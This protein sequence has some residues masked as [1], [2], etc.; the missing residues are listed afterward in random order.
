MK[1]ELKSLFTSYWK[2][3]SIYNACKIKLFDA[4]DVHRGN[5]N[6]LAALH[7]WNLIALEAL[8]EVCSEEGLV[9]AEKDS[10]S[11]TAKGK[12]LV[13]THSDNL[14]YACL[15]W[16][17]EHLDAWRALDYTIRSGKSSF[18][19][20][21][22]N[23]YFD[24]LG[25]NQSKLDE[26]HNAMFAYAIDDYSQLNQILNLPPQAKVIDIGG[27]YG[28]LISMLKRAQ[29][30]LNCALFDLPEVIQ[31]VHLS[32]ITKHAGNFF[33]N[34]PEGYNHYIVS[35]ILH[36]WNDEKSKEILKNIDKVMKSGSVLYIIENFSDKIENKA[37][38]L[39]LNMMALCESHERT[40][41]QYR[42]LLKDFKFTNETVQLN[43]L[44]Y[45]IKAT[46]L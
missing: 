4:I 12:Y 16:G 20:L 29:P 19:H 26:Y 27:G 6:E 5:V 15:L 7:N 8:L 18:E 36:D 38:L 22:Q 35:R 13:S 25:K 30:D 21:Y 45:I 34:V 2:F 43:E 44:Q 23:S 11:L 10:I 31:C 32:N 40:E 24:Y 14:Y 42:S 17:G 37:S 1:A 9:A 46:K 33:D 41:Q 28:A 3:M 39:T